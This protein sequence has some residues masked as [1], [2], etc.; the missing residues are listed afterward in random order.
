MYPQPGELYC[1]STSGC[2]LSSSKN[3]MT[4]IMA[5]MVF[6]LWSAGMVRFVGAPR[7]VSLSFPRQTRHPDGLHNLAL[8]Q[9]GGS[10]KASSYDHWAPSQ[11]H[12]AFLVDGFDQ[13]PISEKW[14][15]LPADV[16]PWVEIRWGEPAVLEHIVIRHAGTKEDSD[17]TARRYEVSCLQGS[18]HGRSVNVIDNSVNVAS[19]PLPC[20]G[21]LGVRLAVWPNRQGDV[22]R[23]YEVEAW[24]SM[25]TAKP[26]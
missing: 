7:G 6:G 8:F 9:Y 18:A 11:H 3:R 4:L 10:V 26:L 5:A 2:R 17:F 24:G 16:A 1:P 12:P 19:H 21:A 14:A 22:V 25:A 13:G 15:T 20:D 23:I